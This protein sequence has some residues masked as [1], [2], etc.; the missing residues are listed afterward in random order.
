M[1]S[2]STAGRILEL[3]RSGTRSTSTS[4]KR[5]DRGFWSRSPRSESALTGA[6]VSLMLP[7]SQSALLVGD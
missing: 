6:P 7:T 5:A 3:N 1:Q 4:R 2:D